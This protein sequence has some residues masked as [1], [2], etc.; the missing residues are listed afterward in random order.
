MTLR[1][2]SLADL[3]RRLAEH[4]AAKRQV[5]AVDLVA[6][7]AVRDYTPEDMTVT[8]EGGLTLAA[9]QATLAARGQ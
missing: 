5:A 7:A 1:P 4:H 3:T 6:L 2:A 8:A 9:L